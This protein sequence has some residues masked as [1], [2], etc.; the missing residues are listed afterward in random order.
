MIHVL[1]VDDTK[2]IRALLTKCLEIE[3]YTVKTA[4]DGKTALEIISNERFDLIFLDIRMPEV[5]GTEVLRR[6]REVG[7]N[8]PVVI[9]TAFGTVKNAVDC[10]QLGAVAYLQK[11]FTENKIK[12][13]LEEMLHIKSDKSSLDNILSL[14]NQKIKLGHFMEAEQLLKNAMTVYSLEPQIYVMLSKV[15]DALKKSEEAKKYMEISEVL[16]KMIFD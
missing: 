12:T 13:V 11:P 5:S 15:C 10:T 3:G 6:M 16:N 9:I 2:N 1:V 8:T 7:I 14:A 4:A